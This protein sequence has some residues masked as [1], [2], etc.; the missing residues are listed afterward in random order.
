MGL[1]KATGV[2]VNIGQSCYV[3]TTCLHIVLLK[4]LN[5][6]SN[7]EQNID[8]FQ[9]LL[10]FIPWGC[11][12]SYR[13]HIKKLKYKKTYLNDHHNLTSTP[14]ASDILLNPSRLKIYRKTLLPRYM[15]I[16]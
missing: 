12:Q 13:K 7:N 5:W 14:T 4:S 9:H 6:S 8:P 10:I 15:D 16:R 3:Y 1:N 2:H 11:K